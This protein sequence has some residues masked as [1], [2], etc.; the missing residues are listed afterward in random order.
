MAEQATLQGRNAAAAALTET[1]R[2]LTRFKEKQNISTRL[3]RQK[4]EKV[5]AA[6]DTLINKHFLYA[7]K[8][9]KDLNSE[10]LLEW[11][12][13]KLDEANDLVDEVFVILEEDETKKNEEKSEIRK[14]L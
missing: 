4:Y 6:K 9:R 14:L 8:S 5:I 10:E 11:L 7:E 3:L 2:E 1:M 12:T 13:P